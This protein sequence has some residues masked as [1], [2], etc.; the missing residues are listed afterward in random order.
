MADGDPIS[1]SLK[2][3]FSNAAQAIRPK[4]RSALGGTGFFGSTVSVSLLNTTAITATSVSAS[5]YD[6]ASSEK[7]EIQWILP[8]S[9]RAKK[10][11]RKDKQVKNA[12]RK[13]AKA[14]KKRNRK[15]R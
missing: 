7:R 6:T 3:S 1:N 5:Y 2:R 15:K 4:A 13:A 12:K 14:A 10:L 8:D 11:S 9:D